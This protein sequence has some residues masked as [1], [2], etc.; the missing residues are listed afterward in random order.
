[1]RLIITN[2]IASVSLLF[3]ILYGLGIEDMLDLFERC[4]VIC[5]AAEKFMFLFAS[6]FLQIKSLCPYLEQS[7][8]Q[9]MTLFKS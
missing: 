9:V 6:T 4:R 2:P 3:A 8:L 5:K 7:N 1:M